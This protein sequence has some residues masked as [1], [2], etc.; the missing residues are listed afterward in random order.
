MAHMILQ[1]KP[2]QL[3]QFI[4]SGKRSATK[5]IDITL[6]KWM[7]F[8]EEKK[9]FVTKYMPPPYNDET[10]A[11]LY[12]IIQKQGD[13]PDD[14]WPKY[15]IQIHGHA[16]ELKNLYSNHCIIKSFFQ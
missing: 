6:L 1:I 11:T 7:R 5:S 16:G 4:S 9:K 13:V 14:S 3:V 8:D 12:D 15:V 10:S 2:F